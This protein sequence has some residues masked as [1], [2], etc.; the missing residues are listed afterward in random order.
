MYIKLN[1]NIVGLFCAF[2]FLCAAWAKAADNE[3]NSLMSPYKITSYGEAQNKKDACDGAQMKNM[4]H[5]RFQIVGYCRGQ[6]DK[7][8]NVRITG[9]VAEEDIGQ[10]RDCV[11]K[12]DSMFP[13]N[14]LLQRVTCKA[15]VVCWSNKPTKDA[16]GIKACV[17]GKDRGCAIAK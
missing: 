11:V 8:K 4:L 16:P 14:K 6:S 5:N 12:V 10:C 3:S 7:R 13:D 2:L 9:G 1:R 17:P 15:D